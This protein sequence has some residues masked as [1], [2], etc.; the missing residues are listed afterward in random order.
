MSAQTY[1]EPCPLSFDEQPEE[2]RRPFVEMTNRNFAAYNAAKALAFANKPFRFPTFEGCFGPLHDP[3]AKKVKE[4]ARY[5]RP[6]GYADYTDDMMEALLTARPGDKSLQA[7]GF[8][9][10][11]ILPRWCLEEFFFKMRRLNAEVNERVKRYN[12]EVLA[13]AAKEA[14]EAA[15]A[16]DEAAK[17]AEEAKADAAPAEA[18]TAVRLRSGYG[19]SS[20]K[21]SS[22]IG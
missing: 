1:H 18:T 7:P 15:K 6:T 5:Y 10:L 12:E 11:E 3:Y 16:A 21:A 2:V 14:E 8:T 17:A 22:P 4:G 20:P 9:E 19:A 13:A